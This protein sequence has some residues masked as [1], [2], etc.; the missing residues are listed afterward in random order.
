MRVALED[1]D[2]FH[3]VPSSAFSS[4]H[5]FQT[6][7]SGSSLFFFLPDFSSASFLTSVG[8]AETFFDVDADVLRQRIICKTDS[9]SKLTPLV[10]F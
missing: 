4:S 7:F 2:D 8:V 1:F 6:S 9:F 10:K 3:L 5:H